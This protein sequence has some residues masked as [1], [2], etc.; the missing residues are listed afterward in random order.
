MA[1]DHRL[2]ST[3]SWPAGGTGKEEKKH[4]TPS[5]EA[6][7]TFKRDF[8]STSHLYQKDLARKPCHEPFFHTHTQ[9]LLF[10]RTNR[11]ARIDAMSIAKGKNPARHTYLFTVQDEQMDK[12]GKEEKGE[13]KAVSILIRNK[14]RNLNKRKKL[15]VEQK[16]LDANKILQTEKWEL[17]Q[18]SCFRWL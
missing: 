5:Q 13:K 1:L 12:E 2:P 9:Q 6:G 8:S 16:L 14:R 10:L 3:I 15:A 17:T 11:E 7:K 4:L 18:T